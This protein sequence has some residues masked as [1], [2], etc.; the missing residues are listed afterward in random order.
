MNRETGNGSHLVANNNR[1]FSDKTWCRPT[2]SQ[3]ERWGARLDDVSDRNLI[4]DATYASN[5]TWIEQWRYLSGS[6]SKLGL[7]SQS[8]NWTKWYWRLCSHFDQIRILNWNQLGGIAR[9]KTTNEEDSTFSDNACME[10]PTCWMAKIN[11][12]SWISISAQ[13]RSNISFCPSVLLWSV[14]IPEVDPLMV[15]RS[16]DSKLHA[17]TFPSTK[18]TW[19]SS[20]RKK[21][22]IEKVTVGSFMGRESGG[23]LHWGWSSSGDH[24]S[25]DLRTER[26]FSSDF[27]FHHLEASHPP[28]TRRW[29]GGEP[30]RRELTVNVRCRRK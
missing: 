12:L 2:S 23:R 17:K 29:V 30:V 6:R 22:I 16:Q 28:R 20:N 21:D 1:E 14:E 26:Y 25:T 13:N 4:T 11:V 19:N 27:E 8:V 9:V 10:L 24:N 18:F 3:D 5:A 15:R 7:L